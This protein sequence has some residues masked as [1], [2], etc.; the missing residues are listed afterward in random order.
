MI[1]AFQIMKNWLARPCH[2]GR[3]YMCVH[4]PTYMDEYRVPR[5]MLDKGLMEE[6]GVEEGR[7]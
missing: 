6:E 1:I 4:I 2:Y 3:T 7:E 5:G